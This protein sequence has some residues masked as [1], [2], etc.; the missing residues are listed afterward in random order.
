[1]GP[2]AE[3]C[4]VAGPFPIHG[5]SGRR[6]WILVGGSGMYIVLEGIYHQGRSRFRRGYRIPPHGESPAPCRSTCRGACLPVLRVAQTTSGRPRGG[7]ARSPRGR[8]R[9]CAEKS[10]PA[11]PGTREES[12]SRKTA[13][14]GSGAAGAATDDRRAL[15]AAILLQNHGPERSEF[16]SSP[17]RP[18][19]LRSMMLGRCGAGCRKPT[20]ATG[21]QASL[22]V[23]CSGFC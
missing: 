22:S 6:S 19:C 4:P 5:R 8:P 1:V 21:G 17:W 18:R 12:A 15:Y 10:P 3:R 16:P 14:C 20:P 2:N 7:P 23:S 9:A 11:I 13:T